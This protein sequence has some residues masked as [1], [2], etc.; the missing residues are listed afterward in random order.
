ME[1]FQLRDGAIVEDVYGAYT[2]VIAHLGAP[3]GR[4]WW[5]VVG[6][7]AFT[8]DL[9]ASVRSFG[10]LLKSWTRSTPTSSALSR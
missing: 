1:W 4:K 10:F 3:R 7:F 5:K 6:R 8:S 2:Q 9:V